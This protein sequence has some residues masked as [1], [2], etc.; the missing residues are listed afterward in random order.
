MGRNRGI[1]ADIFDRM[2][3]RLAE[4]HTDAPISLI[5]WSLGGLIARE[6]AKY[7][8]HR[9][10]KVISLGS[11]FSGGPRGITLGGYMR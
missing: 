6:Y 8:P 4:L 9:V 3:D 1:Q 11:P 2:D 10:A 5:G 7:A